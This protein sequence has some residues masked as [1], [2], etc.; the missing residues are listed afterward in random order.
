MYDR[1]LSAQ[2][3][4]EFVGTFLLVL[5][6]NGAI[7][8]AV[9]TG[10]YDLMGV[11]LMWFLALTVAIYAAGAVSGAHF[12]PAV[13][14]GLAA[15]G[16]FNRAKVVPYMLAQ[17]AGAFVA[18]AAVHM[19]FGGLIAAFESALPIVRGEPGSQL[20][21]MIFTTYAPNPAIVGTTAEAFAQVAPW[22]WFV[23]EALAT[24]LLVFGIA[25]LVADENEGRPLGNAAPVVIGLLL[26][27][28]VGLVA[29][30]TMAALNPARDLG[31]RLW[32]LLAGWGSVALPGPRNGFWI[33]I[34][35]PLVGGLLGAGA[36]RHLYRSAFGVTPEPGREPPEA[37]A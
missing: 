25:Y 1:P 9:T 16:G 26:G 15:F 6:G 3:T 37:Q 29:P 5:I 32:A 30:V 12:N 31:P 23:T 33:P 7:A 17:L 8:V 22:R 11:A 10:A 13:T 14:V 4:A 21:A 18:A 2:V 36:Y 34:A 19:V 20:T 24:A 27:A 28:L 35:A